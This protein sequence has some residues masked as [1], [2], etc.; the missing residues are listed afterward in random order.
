[1]IVVV[2]W[3][4]VTEVI[5][6]AMVY[7]ALE[8]CGVECAHGK[9]DGQQRCQCDPGWSGHNCDLVPCDP[10]C[11]LHGFCS[12]GTC[13]CSQGWNGKHCS[14]GKTEPAITLE[15]QFPVFSLEFKNIMYTCII[16]MIMMMM[17]TTM[18]IWSPSSHSL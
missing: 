13:V 6:V 12:N 10:R 7:S 4:I 1:M 17:A 3:V 2:V 16:M 14:L 9:C 15:L 11:A 18:M 5:M 8:L